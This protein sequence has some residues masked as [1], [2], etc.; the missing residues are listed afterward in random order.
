[1]NTRVSP[2]IDHS[3]L[4]AGRRC[5]VV[6]TNSS[7]ASKSTK[8]MQPAVPSRHTAGIVVFLSF[9]GLARFRS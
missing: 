4:F 3:T 6:M 9:C 2:L 5:L 8:L 1:M 7:L